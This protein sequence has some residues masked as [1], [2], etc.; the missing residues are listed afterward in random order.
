M[1][2][3]LKRIDQQVLLITGASS[4]IGLV[5]AQTAANLGAKVILVARNEEALQTAAADIVNAGGEAI[6]VV[7]DVADPEAF[8]TAAEKGVA[9]FGRI[10]TWVNN[11]GVGMWEDITEAHLEDEKRLFETNFWG[12][13][14]GSR[15]AVEYL[16]DTGGAL[17]NLGSVVSDVS[18]PP[19]GMYSASKHAVLGFTDSLRIE[20]KS[21]GLPIS[22][23]LIKPA[24]IDTPFP[25]NAQNYFDKEASL[26]PPVYD[27]S[28]VASAILFAATHP[29][30]E[31]HA[32][33]GGRLMS[34]MQ[35]EVPG[36]VDFL[37][38]TKAM[39]AKNFVDRPESDHG[40]ALYEPHIGG[41]T[42][43]KA[44]QNRMVQTH[45]AYNT[46]AQHPLISST[47]VTLAIA[48]LA[49]YLLLKHDEERDEGWT[50]KLGRYGSDIRDRVSDYGSAAGE[51]A[52]RYGRAASDRANS[53]GS[54]AR[55]NVSE[56]GHGV[57]D[58]RHRATEYGEDLV[59]S[60]TRGAAR[61]ASRLSRQAA[62]LAAKS[63]S[64][65]G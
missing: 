65:W 13:V 35:R 1:S 45:S 54:A 30:R 8:R 53:F 14:N 19:Q 11:A 56:Y 62:S 60:L 52:S 46:I 64:W 28:L 39:F 5:T 6:A 47:V 33:G 41:Q 20:L 63:Q 37:F 2:V 49:A 7:A 43:G 16:R 34:M 26:P 21:A 29:R 10:D 17:I 57:A 58:L 27:P 59:G 24:A 12:V 38:S 36:V 3:Q 55:D 23:T 22:V 32:G 42:R 9:R 40:S 51:V 48:G 15:L 31:L 18:I 61:A 4:G 25:Q 44:G 50:S